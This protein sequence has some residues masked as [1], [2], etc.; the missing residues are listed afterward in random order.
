MQLFEKGAKRAHMWVNVL[1]G[2]MVLVTG[3]WLW[4]AKVLVLGASGPFDAIIG[5]SAPLILSL[6]FVEALVLLR[7]VR[8]SEP[9]WKQL[10][11][12]LLFGAIYL[13]PHLARSSHSAR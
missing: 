8:S 3:Y 6:H 13:A 12:T 7:R 4:V 11:Q 9:F 10:A 5:L 2:L 1:R